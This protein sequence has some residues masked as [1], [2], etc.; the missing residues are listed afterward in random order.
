VRPVSWEGVT[1]SQ[2]RQNFIR[3]YLLNYYSI[4]ELAER[5]SVSRKTAHKWIDR[6]RREG[7]AGLGERSRRPL[8]CPGQTAEVV[9]AEFI[10][11]KGR[12]QHWGARK[13]LKVISDKHPQWEMPSEIT[14]N[15]LLQREGLTKKRRRKG[16]LH[17]GC[18]QSKAQEPNHIWAADYKGQFRLKN[19]SYCFPLT[20]SDLYS[21][22]LLGCEAHPGISHEKTKSYFEWLFREYGL[23]QRIRTDNGVPFASNALARLSRLSVWWIKLGIY[24]E[25]IEPGK[26]QQNGIHERMHRTLKAEATI[27]P[28]STETKQQQ[29]FDRFRAEFN[30]ERP[31][32]AIGMS[33]PAQVY[34]SSARRM[35]KKLQSYDYPGHYLVRRV[36]RDGTVRMMGK[37]FFVATP[38]MEDYIGFEEQEEGVYDMYFCFYHIGRYNAPKNKVEG[39]ISKVAVTRQLADAGWKRVTD[40]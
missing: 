23:P 16:R 15:R 11:Q 37:Q 24:P 34:Q 29:R 14:V 25:L 18:P 32:E 1:V 4:S 6:F 20:V 5:F 10:R 8:H 27:P 3:D 39:V 2:Q 40:V 17:P 21:R 13:L 31:H 9:S 19:G 35:P 36:S 12:H 38:L 33:S 7:E 30:N 28:E 26:P 22:Y